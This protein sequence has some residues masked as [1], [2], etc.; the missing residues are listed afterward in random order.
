M[1][2]F[3]VLIVGAGISGIGAAVHLKARCPGQRWAILEAR[4]ELGGTWDLFRYPGVRSDSD[5]YTLGFSFR[6]W[7]ESRAIVDGASILQYLQD[8][9]REQGLYP[10]LRFGHSVQRASWS[11]TT[12]RWTVTVERRA[13]GETL[14]LTCEFLFMCTGYYDYAKGHSPAFTGMERF[15]G[16]IVHPQHWSTDLEYADQRVVVIGSGATALTMVPALAKTAAHVTLLQRSPSYV[17][18]VPAHDAWVAAL[19]SILGPERAASV[20]R[21][22][23]ILLGM[24]V[25]QLCRRLPGLARKLLV[26]RTRREL[27]PDYDVKSHFSPRYPPW[28]QRLCIAPDGD[29]FEVIRSGQASVVTD[30][31]V[32]FTETG[33]S[34]ESGRQLP[35]DLVITATGLELQLMG[36]LE[37]TVDG[38]RIDAA[39]SISYRGVMFSGIPNLA[40]CFGYTNA[41]WT[42]RSELSARFVCRLL[43]YMARHGYQQCRPRH[44]RAGD[45]S[46]PLVDFSSGYVKRGIQ[47]F[48]RQG[49]RA[50]WRVRQNYLWDRLDTCWTAFSDGSLE[51]SSLAAPRGSRHAAQEGQIV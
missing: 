4:D 1:E 21:W 8:T 35:A 44:P 17:L 15:R 45:G 43:E 6:P 41:S 10:A 19:R 26:N 30:A 9:A 7:T 31:I 50:P 5:M 3:D 18:A 29:L 28:D 34:L 37:I 46:Q 33:L 16:R 49:S 36:S 38:A 2:H 27:G 11:S 32:T 13:T 42:L 20:A 24:F 14:Q 25:F 12:A 39:K 22:R 23:N 40:N 48:P 47:R 51:F